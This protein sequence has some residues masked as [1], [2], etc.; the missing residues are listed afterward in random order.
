MPAPIAIA[1]SLT[2]CGKRLSGGSFYLIRHNFI[3]RALPLL[4]CGDFC[5]V[6]SS[7]VLTFVRRSLVCAAFFAGYLLLRFA[8]EL[9]AGFRGVRYSPSGLW[10][11]I[12][13]S[14]FVI[15]CERRFMGDSLL[16]LI[17]CYTVR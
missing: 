12:V 7:I 13:C 15:L 14:T 9:R 4:V 11:D 3:S 8:E 1:R 6:A 10:L 2:L 16:C 5:C 17:V